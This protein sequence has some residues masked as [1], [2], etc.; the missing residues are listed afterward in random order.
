M[1]MHLIGHPC[2]QK[3]IPIS[4]GH[5][6]HLHSPESLLPFHAAKIYL[7]LQKHPGIPQIRIWD[8][9]LRKGQRARAREPTMPWRW[10]PPMTHAPISACSSA[11]GS[12]EKA[13]DLATRDTSTQAASLPAVFVCAC[14]RAYVHKC[15]CACMH[16]CE[17]VRVRA[18]VRACECVRASACVRAYAPARSRAAR[19]V[20]TDA[21][22]SILATRLH[23]KKHDFA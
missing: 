10:R 6:L 20:P 13:L 22:P 3:H 11:S 19:S 9:A 23:G 15:V 8:L 12:R 16:A 14:V 17:C 2:C 18:C 1:P 7:T 5:I 21:D 4:H